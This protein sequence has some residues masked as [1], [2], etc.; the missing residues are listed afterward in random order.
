MAKNRVFSVVWCQK[1]SNHATCVEFIWH[2]KA[3]LGCNLHACSLTPVQ[4]LVTW[5]G[6]KLVCEQTGEKKNRGWAHWIE[7]DKLHLV[8][9]IWVWTV[10]SY[11]WHRRL[12]W[13]SVHLLHCYTS[14]WP[15]NEH[16]IKHIFW[17]LPLRSCTVKDKSASRSLRGKWLIE[18]ESLEKSLCVWRHRVLDRL[19]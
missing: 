5:Q 18:E 1:F 13:L 14:W 10:I 11:L 15:F 8:K 17:W 6:N 2:A 3:A 19:L 12:K 9:K 7:E 4:S 16:I